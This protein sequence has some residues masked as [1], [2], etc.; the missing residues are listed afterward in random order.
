MLGPGIVFLNPTS[1]VTIVVATTY[2]YDTAT[3]IIIINSFIRSHVT[4]S[5]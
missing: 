2:S 1:A 4:N 3:I 5:N